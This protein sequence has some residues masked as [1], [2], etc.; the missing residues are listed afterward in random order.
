MGSNTGYFQGYWAVK[1]NEILAERRRRYETDPAY[2]AKV[3]AASR[4][5]RERKRKGR[6]KVPRFMRPSVVVV[7]GVETSAFSIGAFAKFIGRSIQ[8]LNQWQ[9]HGI[10]PETPFRDR[11]G[12]RLYTASQMDAVATVIGD[13]KRLYPVNPEWPLQIRA[14]WTAAGIPVDGDPD[15]TVARAS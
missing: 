15:L 9:D 14:A 1:G 11:R 2:K 6:V 12:F 4:D 10:L 13:R 8:A 3:L 7:R 5:Y